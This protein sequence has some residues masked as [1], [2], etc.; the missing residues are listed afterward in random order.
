MALGP[1]V[2]QHFVGQ[3]DGS[4]Q[5]VLGD[6]LE[7]LLVELDACLLAGVSDP[8]GG[9]VALGQ[10]FLAALRL[11][12]QV[13]QDF[14]IIEGIGGLAGLGS[15]LLGEIHHDR[16]VPEHA[17]Q[18]VV[19][20]GADHADQAVL[21]LDHRDVECAA[22]Q[23]VNQ[24]GLVL[25][26]L[27]A[28]GDGGGG[29]L[30]QDRPHVQA[31]QPAGV[32]RRLAFRRAEIG[33]A[34]DH[35]IGDLVAERDLGVTDDLAQDE[36][37]DVLG[38]E[39]LPL[40]LKDEVGVAHVLLDPRD[41]PVRLDLG[42]LL[43]GIA[44]DDAVAVEQDDRGRDPLTLL[45]GD[46]DGLSVLVDIRDRR[47]SGSQVD[48]VNAFETFGHGRDSRCSINGQV[49]NAADTIQIATSRGPKTCRRLDGIF[50]RALDL[51]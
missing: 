29:G 46:D 19:A 12:E 17:P 33:R 48:P 2:G 49:L 7:L 31:R 39:G 42:R 45:V 40:V 35:D 51:L 22:P 5:Q 1:G 9:L 14:G 26:L 25:A 27:E 4:V 44:D 43:G 34:G 32:G 15:K 37:R 8:E 50:V 13:V 10:R 36:R 3:L 30:V 41:D 21:D 20:A 23:V 6:L 38:A 18:P 28:I 47:V 24:N 11:E 16:L